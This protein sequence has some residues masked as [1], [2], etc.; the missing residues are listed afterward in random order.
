MSYEPEVP[1]L[2]WNLE[3]H[4]LIQE[5][6]AEHFSEAVNPGHTLILFL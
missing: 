3:V 1:Y 6:S 2:L 4:C 5:F